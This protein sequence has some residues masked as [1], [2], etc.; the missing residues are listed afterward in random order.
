M[1]NNR[2]QGSVLLWGLVILLTLTVIG[3]AATQVASVD[4]RIAG[5]QMFYMLTY[6]GAES[7]LNRST[8]LFSIIQTATNGVYDTA[9]AAKTQSFGPFNDTVSGGT[10]VS[11]SSVAMGAEISCPPLNGVAMSV[12]MSPESGSIACRVF[13]TDADA[14]LAGTGADSKHSEGILKPLPSNN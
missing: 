8:N 2:Q 6:Q 1:E 5:N 10:T 11:N 12:S 3:V 14:Q 13:T 9:K 4:T 7:T